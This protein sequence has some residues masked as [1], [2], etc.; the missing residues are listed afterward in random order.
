MYW[1]NANIAMSEGDYWVTSH[2]YY[3]KKM[4]MLRI[5]TYVKYVGDQVVIVPLDVSVSWT[6]EHLL[7]MIYSKTS[8][9]KKTISISRQL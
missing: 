7:S 8:I 4:I 2:I 9:E 5:E 6:Y 1:T 3:L